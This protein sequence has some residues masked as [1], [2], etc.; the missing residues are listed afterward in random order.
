MKNWVE[1]NRES[2]DENYCLL[3]PVVS[4][5]F[6][7]GFL[8]TSGERV[9]ISAAS[10]L[11]Q[12][13][14]SPLNL[15][16]CSLED[17][18]TVWVVIAKDGIIYGD[19]L[20]PITSANND[21]L[22][23]SVNKLI[24]NI[25]RFNPSSMESDAEV[26]I[27][28]NDV[29]Q[30]DDGSSIALI[31]MFEFETPYDV[32]VKR[33]DFDINVLSKGKSFSKKYGLIMSSRTN[34]PVD[35]RYYQAFGVVVA[36]FVAMFIIALMPEK[37]EPKENVKLP[38]AVVIDTFKGLKKLL[39]NGNKAVGIK[40]RFS[41]IV[42]EL[43]AARHIEGYNISSYTANQE[44]SSITLKRTFG[45]ID[46][47]KA[48]L[49]ESIFYY[50]PTSGG[51]SLYRVTPKFPVFK[52]A[53]RANTYGEE[54]WI[55]SALLYAWPDHIGELKAKAPVK[56]KK[57]GKY[58][59]YEYS[60]PFNELYLEDLENMSSLFVGRS[61]SFE[62]LNFTVDEENKSYSGELKIKIIG[63]PDE[64]FGIKKR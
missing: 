25:E 9:G 30:N 42:N 39:T 54:A 36:V 15:I 38:E 64:S 16:Y 4:S 31:G 11:Y 2:K 49:P 34:F 48:K 22:Q 13:L 17:E 55:E 29:E 14:G 60:I 18:N 19:H 46:A 62:E 35:E 43:N 10:V 8:I 52:K 1:D 5:A 57:G 58:T 21:A 24:Q 59:A 45:S 53:V 40:Q 27:V 7:E 3:E 51:L 33:T 37:L 44:A 23:H 50:Q 63:V 56:N 12:H 41:F 26:T 47:V 6:G 61:A 28:C 32:E 20:I